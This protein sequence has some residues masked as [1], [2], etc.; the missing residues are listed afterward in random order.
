MEPNGNI[1]APSPRLPCTMRPSNVQYQSLPN[2]EKRISSSQLL[3]DLKLKPIETY[4]DQPQMRWDGH[5]SRMPWNQLP[6]M[7][8]PAWCNSKRPKG[9]PQ[10][11]YGWNLKKVFKRRSVDH[12]TWMTR[13][14]N[15]VRWREKSDHLDNGSFPSSTFLV[16]NSSVIP[17]FKP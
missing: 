15:W 11:T 8:L 10:R 4:I 13:S 16:N 7:M 5:V 1:N 17:R 14:K 3:N 2:T 12:K 6:R 9:A